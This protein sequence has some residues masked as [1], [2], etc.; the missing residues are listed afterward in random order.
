MYLECKYDVI[1][2]D[3]K[4][5]DV[6]NQ[7]KNWRDAHP[8]KPAPALI[9]CDIPRSYADCQ[10]SYGCLESI[11]NGLLYSG[12]YEGGKVKLSPTHIVC[13]ANH[14]PEKDKLSE[15]RWNI[16]NIDE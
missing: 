14:K 4:K 16:V 8:N 7:L 11:K 2:C 3:G 12:K 1:I 9:I 10:I 15:D 6:F 5:G 13:F